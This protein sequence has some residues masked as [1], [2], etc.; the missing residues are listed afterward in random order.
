MNAIIKLNVP[1]FQIGQ[2]VSIYFPDTMMQKGIVEKDRTGYWETWDETVEVFSF[3]FDTYK[4]DIQHC[5]CSECGK[6]II[7]E[8]SICFKYCPFC[9]TKMDDSR[10]Q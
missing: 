3:T 10:P 1:E 6:E 5:K 8:E 4:E 2:E 7:P 9:G